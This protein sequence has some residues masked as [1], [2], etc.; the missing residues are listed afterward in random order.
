[1]SDPKP[2]FNPLAIWIPVVMMALGVVIYYNYLV[3]LQEKQRSEDK[4]RPAFLGRLE[5]DM[6]LT[7]RDGR[8][9]HLE[10]LRGKIL[11]ASWVYTRCPRGCAG[12]IAKLKQLQEQYKGNPNIHFLS[13]TLDP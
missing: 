4:D 7:E 5:R 12:V 8:K 6:E 13:F 1:M 3:F 10:E 9:V 11:L 2:R